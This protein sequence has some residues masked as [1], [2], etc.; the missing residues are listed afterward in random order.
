MNDSLMVSV[1]LKNTGRF[2]AEEVAQLYIR[3]RVLPLPG[4]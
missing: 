4:R 1:I 2:E 3:D